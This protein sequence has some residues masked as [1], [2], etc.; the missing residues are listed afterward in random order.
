VVIISTINPN[1]TTMKAI[2]TKRIPCTD[3]KPDR[4]KTSAEG[5]PSKI[6]FK[7]SLIDELNNEGVPVTAENIHRLAAFHF[8]EERGWEKQNLATGQLPSGDWVHCFIPVDQPTSAE[9][10]ARTDALLAVR[11]ATNL[12]VAQA[13]I[14]VAESPTP[15]TG[16]PICDAYHFGLLKNALEKLDRAPVETTEARCPTCGDPVPT[17]FEHVD[18]C[19][20]E[21]PKPPDNYHVAAVSSNTNSFGYKSVLAISAAGLGVQLLVQA[22]G[23]DKVPEQ[24]DVVRLGESR[25]YGAPV[26]LPSVTP[27]KAAKLIKTLTK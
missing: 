2:I 12:V 27:E 23:T 16:L 5:V 10:L 24:G 26:A 13:R 20:Q 8:R 21:A 17:V 25:W 19:P 22:Y 18:G 14:L 11:E 1:N 9:R 7:N 6:Y 15:E 4:V 3:T